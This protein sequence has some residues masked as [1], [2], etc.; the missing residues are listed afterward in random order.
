MQENYSQEN[1]I[2]QKHTVEYNQGMLAAGNPNVNSTEHH[3][4]AR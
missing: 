1:F 2:S 3:W 4:S